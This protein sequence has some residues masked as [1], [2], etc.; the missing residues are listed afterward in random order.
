[1]LLTLKR[2][3]GAS[4][5]LASLDFARGPAVAGQRNYPYANSIPCRIRIG[6]R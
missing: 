3:A 1:M 4:A 5:P 6:N 2:R